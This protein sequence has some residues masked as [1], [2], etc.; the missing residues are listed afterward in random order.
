MIIKTK[1]YLSKAFIIP[2]IYN[3][4]DILNLSE[5]DNDFIRKTSTMGLKQTI[6]VN[7]K[8]RTLESCLRLI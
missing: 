2:V 8:K 3:G 5:D 1:G 6:G 7:N 4:L